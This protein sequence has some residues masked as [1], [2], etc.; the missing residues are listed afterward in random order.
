MERV[1]PKDRLANDQNPYA[2]SGSDPEAALKD[3]AALFGTAPESPLL[4]GEDAARP[5]PAR[6][7]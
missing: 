6:I 4:P 7:Q 2:P 1:K 3:L 5:A